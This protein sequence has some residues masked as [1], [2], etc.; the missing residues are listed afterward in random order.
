MKGVVKFGA[1]DLTAHSSVG[2]RYSIKNY[3]TIKIF[4]FN[5]GL[6]QDYHGKKFVVVVA[7]CLCGL[8]F[9]YFHFFVGTIC[10]DSVCY[11]KWPNVCLGKR[12]AAAITNEAWKRLKRMVKES[13]GGGG[14]SSDD[15]VYLTDANFEEEVLGT[16]ELVLVAF[17]A[18]W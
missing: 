10:L 9:F 3:L 1:V 13:G 8:I 15:V 11:F 2:G 17:Y 6:P 18:P 14:G 16:K 5:K 12:T 7:C 4:G